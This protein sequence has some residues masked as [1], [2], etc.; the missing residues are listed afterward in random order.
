MTR[1][2]DGVGGV[3]ATDR[4][5]RPFD[6]GDPLF[7]PS[8]E[9]AVRI[10]AGLLADGDWETLARYYDLSAVDRLAEP[11]IDVHAWPDPDASWFTDVPAP[12]V[13]IAPDPAVRFRHPFPPTFE[14][15]DHEVS[16][17]GDHETTG[18]G[19]D[20][21][22]DVATVVVGGTWSPGPEVESQSGRWAFELVRKEV[23]WQVLPTPVEV[24][25]G[26]R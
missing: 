16:G 4:D 7:A 3:D 5:D 15:V 14:Y 17:D 1:D 12:H 9:D 24:L 2:V 19:D 20:V 6:V 18:D 22:G 26:D 21:A 25:E 8:P 11:G 10:L 13:A 23:G